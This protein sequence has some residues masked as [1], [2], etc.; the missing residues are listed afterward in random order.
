MLEA[1]H[2]VVQVLNQTPRAKKCNRHLQIRNTVF[3]FVIKLYISCFPTKCA[4]GLSSRKKHINVPLQKLKKKTRSTI[5][6][7][8][9]AHERFK[10]SLHPN[11]K[12]RFKSSYKAGGQNPTGKICEICIAC[13][14]TIKY[15]GIFFLLKTGHFVS[16]V[17]QVHE[18]GA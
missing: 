3:K 17:F 2:F 7:Y 18:T 15:T 10:I 16:Q 1:L 11:L 12:I 4:D 6:F 13:T 14:F 8:F 5:F 9:L